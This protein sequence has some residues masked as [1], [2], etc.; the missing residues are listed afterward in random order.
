M[1]APTHPT[2]IPI[3]RG[4]IILVLLMKTNSKSSSNFEFE[5]YPGQFS[6]AKLLQVNSNLSPVSQLTKDCL[7]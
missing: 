2:L 3:P 1:K 5:I 6:A 4:Y 7:I